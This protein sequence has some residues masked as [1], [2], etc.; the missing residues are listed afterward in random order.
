MQAAA[1]DRTFRRGVIFDLDGTLVDSLGD[2]HECL[3]LALRALGLPGRN[4]REVRLMIG[5]GIRHLFRRAAE[6][7]DEATIEAMRR[8]Y[9]P[10]YREQM[11]LDIHPY[12]GVLAV[13]D[14]LTRRHV[15]MC[16]LSNKNHEF[17]AAITAAFAGPERFV[18]VE[19]S[20]EGA[21]RKPDPTIALSMATAMARTP[22]HVYLVGD[23]ATDVRTARNAGMRAIG[24]AWG[25]RGREELIA[26]GADHVIDHPSQIPEIVFADRYAH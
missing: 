26:A 6:T 25:Y 24:A 12:P 10:A 14:E 1:D 21:P 2:I 13:L 16:V 15:P 8:I 5:E 23:S 7:D 11:L 22:A 20:R 4:A 18:R 3:N 17:T 9:E 19:G